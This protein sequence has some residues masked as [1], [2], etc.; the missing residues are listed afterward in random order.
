MAKKSTAKAAGKNQ[1][2]KNKSV[3]TN[4]KVKKEPVS[5]ETA[6]LKEKEVKI[7][8]PGILGFLPLS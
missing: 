7:S 1:N 3:K 2:T 5:K 6:D 4:E 8:P